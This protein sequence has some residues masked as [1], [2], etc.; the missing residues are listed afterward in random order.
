METQNSEY[1]Y[2]H[3]FDLSNDMLVIQNFDKEILEVNQT[4]LDYLG[5]RREEVIGKMI[6]D[7]QIKY[8]QKELEAIT[9]SL[10]EKGLVRFESIFIRKNGSSFPTEV[11]AKIID[12]QGKK[13]VFTQSRDISKRK[14]NEK[15]LSRFQKA[16]DSSSEAIGLSN[17]EGVHFY[18]N[19]AFTNLF[20]YQV[21]DIEIQNPKI[22]YKDQAV[23]DEVFSTIF[24]GNSWKG[25]IE[26]VTKNRNIIPIFLRADS[27]RN[28]DG[29]IIGFI[30]IHQDV[31]KQKEA[32]RLI[33]IQHEKTLRIFDSLD[34]LVYV[35]DPIT[36]EVL[37][38]NQKLKESIKIGLIQNGIACYQLFQGL[39]SPCAFCTNHII[40]KE[41]PNESYTWEFQN[42]QNKQWYRCFDKA[43]DWVDGRKVRLEMAIDITDE[44]KAIEDLKKSEQDYKQLFENAHDA[45]IVF[46]P[47]NERILDV[48]QRACEL[49]G[50]SKEEFIG[51]S[52]I[53]ISKNPEKGKEKIYLTIQAGMHHN[54]E[55]IQYHKS[56]QELYFEINASVVD[57]KGQKAIL[58]INRNI[59]DR[60]MAE[61]ALRN[62]EANLSA[63][64]ESSNDSIWSVNKEYHLLTLNT[65]FKNEFRNAYGIELKMGDRIVD[66]V[67]KEEAKKWKE[68]YQ[69]VFLGDSVVETETYYLPNKEIHVEIHINPII[70]RE[71]I[72]G[73]SVLT[74]DISQRIKAQ[75]FLIK[76]KEQAEQSD[77]L[78]SS[79]LANMSHEIRTPMNGI[80]GFAELLK[81]DTLSDDE[82]RLY[83][84]V[85]ERSG[86]KMLRLINNIIDITRIEAGLIEVNYT[87]VNINEIMRFHL[88]FFKL[89]ANRK[90]LDLIWK[91]ENNSDFYIY[92]DHAKIS[93]ILTNLI[94]NAIKYTEKGKIVFYYNVEGSK[95][96]FVVEDTGIGIS[97]EMQPFVFERFSQAETLKN[98][99]IEGSGLGL[100]IVKAYVDILGGEI[101]LESKVNE[102]S[103]FRFSIPLFLKKP[104]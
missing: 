24:Q 30:G 102:G 54:F 19:S 7:F 20:G 58:S 53:E 73:A 81:E 96:H 29:M 37:F 15:K 43:I 92:S 83:I 13:A 51:K 79:F 41:K 42:L 1:Q 56:G 85:I 97:K 74:T 21:D 26:L 76:A 40:F 49:Y 91:G 95:V 65:K 16:F 93:D 4:T 71:E 32:E 64:I 45:I 38:V 101:S 82:K 89:E 8:S 3:L 60:K 22:L 99:S 77:R 62:S 86:G 94:K 87:P 57:Y 25:E 61:I 68:R 66:K 14:Q 98:K 69:R 88:D 39:D 67:T 23:A 33:R 17:K 63:I 52:I 12:Y 31:S 36:Y 75:N 80:M 28:S 35:S 100:A 46:V 44:K 11:I 5:Y 90:S 50:F 9:V 6:S 104:L 103:V 78:K 72:T 2:R 18:H 34:S 84:S 27:I 59:N 55:T 70:H 47:E 10:L 48:N